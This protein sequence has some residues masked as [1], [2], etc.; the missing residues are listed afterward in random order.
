MCYRL[1][2]KVL[3]HSLLL[4]QFY[5]VSFNCEY[6]NKSRTA[7]V[8]VYFYWTEFKILKVKKWA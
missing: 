8:H 6:S 1:M 3:T 2:E 4:I 5:K 7:A